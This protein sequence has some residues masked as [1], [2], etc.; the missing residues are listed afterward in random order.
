MGVVAQS[1]IYSAVTSAGA[2]GDA[3][4][5]LA[6][7]RG[8]AMPA[9]QQVRL[10][11]AASVGHVLGGLAA[12]PDSKNVDRAMARLGGD[13]YRLDRDQ[14]GWECSAERPNGKRQRHQTG[15]N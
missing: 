6:S 14:D 4:I 2:H 7:S 15:Q 3:C 1:D 13:T 9:Y 8:E 5:V 12:V 10:D 11:A